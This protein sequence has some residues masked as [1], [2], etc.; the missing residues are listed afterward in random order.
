[1]RR[2]RGEALEVVIWLMQDGRPLSIIP[3]R[4]AAANQNSG[5]A[6]RPWFPSSMRLECPV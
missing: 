5:R 2:A 3:A 6:T 4:K 1:M